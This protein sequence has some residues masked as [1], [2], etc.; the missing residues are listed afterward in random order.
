VTTAHVNGDHHRSG[1]DLFTVCIWQV[2]TCSFIAV[3][4]LRSATCSN[5]KPTHRSDPP[6]C[7]RRRTRDSE[8]V[9]LTLNRVGESGLR[10]LRDGSLT[11][12][13]LLMAELVNT[14]WSAVKESVSISPLARR[15]RDAHDDCTP[16]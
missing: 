3:S 10:K 12:D 11:A 4:S 2:E 9:D 13:L 15:R 16:A 7:G 1:V 14:Y 8:L 5:A 6:S